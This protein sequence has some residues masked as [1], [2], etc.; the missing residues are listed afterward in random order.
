MTIEQRN[1]IKFCVK[2]GKTATE[3]LKMLRGVYGDSSMFRTRVFE[4]NTRFVEGREDV[5][6]DPKSGSPCTSTTVANIEKVRQ[7]VRSDHRLTIRVI[8]NEVGMDKETV[9]TILVDTLD[10]RK[11]CAKMVP[12]LLT[13][14]LKAQRLNACRDILQQLETDDKLLENVITG[15]ESWVFQYDSETKQQSR[16]RKSASSPRPKKTRMQRAQVK[17]MLITFFDHHGLVHHEFVPQGQTVNQ[18]FY[19]EVLT[20]FVNKICQKRRASWAR[21]TWI[22]HHDNAPAHTALSV[23]QFLVSKEITTLHHPPYS[24]GL[25]PCD[26]FLFPKLKGIL[27]GTSFEGVEDMKA[28]VRNH[29]KT[30]TK[31][32]FSQC[33][34]AWSTRM[35]KRIKA[36]GEYFEED[37]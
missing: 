30:I 8:A 21:K 1:N 34:K 9:R 10:M 16:Q 24:R 19:K 22:L 13:E 2:L 33:F 18:L 4:W 20:R 3:T 26:F 29:L 7:L 6:D 12:R 28:S 32:A 35:E 5:N 36:N 31:E 17:V 14:V 15:D 25:A 27:K 23:K 11:V 37:N